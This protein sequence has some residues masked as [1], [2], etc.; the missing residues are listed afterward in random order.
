[1]IVELPYLAWMAYLRSLYNLR[2]KWTY[3]LLG[4]SYLVFCHSQ[5][6]LIL[7]DTGINTFEFAYNFGAGGGMFMEPKL[8]L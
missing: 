2:G 5:L 3:I 7:S 4:H 8:S 1:M 6:N